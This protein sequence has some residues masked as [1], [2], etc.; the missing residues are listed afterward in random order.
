MNDITCAGVIR[1]SDLWQG[2]INISFVRF[3]W[4][5]KVCCVWR[6]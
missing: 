2:S 5:P 4:L 1:F 6:N 3:P